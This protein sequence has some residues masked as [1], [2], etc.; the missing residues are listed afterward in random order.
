MIHEI[1]EFAGFVEGETYRET[2]FVKAPRETYAVFGDSFERRGADDRNYIKEHD[3]TVEL[4]AY[5]PDPEAEAR[6]EEAFD[7]YGV[8]YEKEERYYLDE[9]SLYQTI[10]HFGFI[11]K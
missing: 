1:L 6:I 7:F 3:A 8:A 10:Y 9:E 11:E 4:Y 5:A 2:R